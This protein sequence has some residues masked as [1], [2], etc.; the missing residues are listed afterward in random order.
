[1]RIICKPHFRG[2]IAKDGIIKVYAEIRPDMRS[3]PI[4]EEQKLFLCQGMLSRGCPIYHD[5]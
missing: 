1:M 4:Q 2:C 3:V 5:Q